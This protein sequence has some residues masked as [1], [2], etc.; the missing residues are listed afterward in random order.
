M[1]P[2]FG[3]KTL[4]RALL[5][6]SR[7][8]P[9]H[10]TRTLAPF[11]GRKSRKLHSRPRRTRLWETRVIPL[12][13]SR[14][15]DQSLLPNR[16][17][18]QTSITRRDASRPNAFPQFQSATS[19]APSP[20]WRAQATV[21]RWIVK[22]RPTSALARLWVTQGEIPPRNRCYVEERNCS[23]RLCAHVVSASRSIWVFV[24]AGVAVIASSVNRT[25]FLFVKRV[26]RSKFRTPGAE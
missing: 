6:Y 1:F 13:R 7:F 12:P 23:A 18:V 3:S 14:R 8:P 20:G 26:Y 24:S 4:D 11:N 19:M 2:C 25:E 22:P 15:V 9:L 5:L 10:V 17:S 16:S 21:Y